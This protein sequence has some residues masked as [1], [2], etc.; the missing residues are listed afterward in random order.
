MGGRTKQAT[1]AM[2]RRELGNIPL[3]RINS[4]HL[5]DFIDK[6]LA[7]G[8]GDVTIAADLS[9]FGSF[10]SGG[11]IH[12]GWTYVLILPLTRTA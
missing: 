9:F 1:R 10:S 11:N 7:A 3:K 6:R 2:L 12:A 5:R 8:T 4:I